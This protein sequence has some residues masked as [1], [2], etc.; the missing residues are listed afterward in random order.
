MTEH[1]TYE[2]ENGSERVS[3][4]VFASGRNV[5]TG[6]PKIPGTAGWR[7]MGNGTEND[8]VTK[9]SSGL[10]GSLQERWRWN[11]NYDVYIGQCWAEAVIDPVNKYVYQT[12]NKGSFIQIDA[13]TGSATYTIDVFGNENAINTAPAFSS[14]WEYAYVVDHATAELYEFDIDTTG[15]G[16]QSKTQLYNA[17]IDTE[18]IGPVIEND[19]VVWYSDPGNDPRV[20]AYDL[21]AGSLAWTTQIA[22]GLSIYRLEPL[23]VSE[24][25]AVYAQSTYQ[26]DAKVK[27]LDLSDG[28]ELWSV[29]AQNAGWSE[30]NEFQSDNS[31]SYDSAT[32]RLIIPDSS[33]Y[34]HCLDAS[35]GSLIWEY[36]VPEN[37]NMSGGTIFRGT[38]YVWSGDQS[39][40]HAI[41]IS[42][43]TEKWTK[44]GLNID[45]EYDFYQIITAASS[46]GTALVMNG[47]GRIIVLD[48]STGEV[49]SNQSTQEGY[50][51]Q[52]CD[53]ELGIAISAEYGIYCY[54]LA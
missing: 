17:G 29:D 51:K 19:I 22:T 8:R 41:N 37:F 26:N 5:V 25:N 4:Y 42:D 32:N 12:T 6:L 18:A 31:M 10:R 11:E 20:Y 21:S 36:E 38:F 44:T 23:I 15:G 45:S 48:P 35:D 9:G 16:I 34:V 28:S 33:T 30:E 50:L 39:S 43:G 27:A 46:S 3:D 1:N 54:E 2:L 53:A 24:N 7:M 52:S 40:V 14:D 13:E 47:G 49:I